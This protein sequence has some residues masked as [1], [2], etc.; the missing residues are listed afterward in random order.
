[1]PYKYYETQDAIHS[2]APDEFGAGDFCAVLGK[3]RWQSPW[4][5][6]AK[7]KRPDLID[8]PT[9]PQL[10]R[11]QEW[12]PDVARELEKSL[13][14]AKPVYRPLYRAWHEKIPWLRPAPDGVAVMPT[15]PESVELKTARDLDAWAVSDLEVSCNEAMAAAD[16]IT[17]LA[18]PAYL[19]QAALGAWCQG[20]DRAYLAGM[21][22]DWASWKKILRIIHVTDILASDALR[23][24]IQTVTA[25][26][27][28]YILGSEEPPAPSTARLAEVKRKG[29][30]AV[31]PTS[32]EAALIQEL[33]DARKTAESAKSRADAISRELCELAGENKAITSPDWVATVVRVSGR[34]SLA[35]GKIRKTAPDLWTELEKRDLVSRGRPSVHARIRR[36]NHESPASS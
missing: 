17:P 21:T 19:I 34:E 26:R 13:R 20:L 8:P 6:W 36:I 30:M 4:E 25:W 12:E 18:P 14:L 16:G 35:A 33:H 10:A 23:D 29:E 9:G 22:I 11:G 28:R 31:E 15:G 24:A 7:R 1:M 2:L 3:S 32:R 5:T 27:E